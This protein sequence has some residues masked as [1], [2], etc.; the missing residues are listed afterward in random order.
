MR[1]NVSGRVVWGDGGVLYIFSQLVSFLGS[2]LFRLW[3]HIMIPDNDPD[4]VKM[5]EKGWSGVTVF[6]IQICP[7][8]R[9]FSHLFSASS[10]MPR[11]LPAVSPPY[12]SSTGGVL[13]LLPLG[14]GRAG[15]AAVWQRQLLRSGADVL[16]SRERFG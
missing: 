11:P 2:F 1:K 6:I 9:V 5:L 15:E 10:S 4:K 8:F 13:M 16:E 3:D 12:E 14:S 7:R